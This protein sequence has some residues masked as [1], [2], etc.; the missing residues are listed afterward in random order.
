MKETRMS[1]SSEGSESLYSTETLG[2]AGF[3]TI[4]YD[5]LDVGMTFRSDDCVVRPEDVIA[6]A[7]AV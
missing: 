4:S 3:P 2:V 1:D 5:I 7:Y 6:Y